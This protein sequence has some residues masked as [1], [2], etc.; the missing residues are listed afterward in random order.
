MHTPCDGVV[1][2]K[3]GWVGEA[4]C[5]QHQCAFHVDEGAGTG[6]PLLDCVSMSMPGSPAQCCSAASTCSHVC[7]TR[8]RRYAD[9]P[10]ML[11][12]QQPGASSSGSWG[13]LSHLLAP[14][15]GIA[16][17]L[18]WVRAEGLWQAAMRVPGVTCCSV[19][20]PGTACTCCDACGAP[21]STPPRL[22]GGRD[23]P[24]RHARAAGGRVPAA[25]HPGAAGGQQQ[26]QQ[27]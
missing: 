2:A 26:Q 23:G 8:A 15:P 5:C 4:C 18:R 14:K 16:I 12:L 19:R 27:Q 25:V 1:A 17:T 3:E 13:A 11:R 7:R 9:T 21:S 20:T 10:Y 6:R 24:R 22:Q